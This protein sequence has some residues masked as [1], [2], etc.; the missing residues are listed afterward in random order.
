MGT[1]DIEQTIEDVMLSDNLYW[2]GITPSEE[3]VEEIVRKVV[4]EVTEYHYSIN[5][6]EIEDWDIWEQDIM[7]KVNDILESLCDYE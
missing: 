2:D 4:T 5:D 7:A 1:V 6:G 3:Q